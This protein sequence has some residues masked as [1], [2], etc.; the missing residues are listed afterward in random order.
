M[1]M[2][3]TNASSQGRPLE[4][5]V[6]ELCFTSNNAPSRIVFGPAPSMR[7]HCCKNSEPKS[8]KQLIP[9]RL[10]VIETPATVAFHGRFCDALTCSA[11]FLR[12]TINR[13]SSLIV[14]FKPASSVLSPPL[15]GAVTG[16]L[17]GKLSI[18]AFREYYCDTDTLEYRMQQVVE[19]G[20][21]D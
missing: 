13:D 12:R 19:K 9:T 1:P 15:L 4:I 10:F 21:Y 16:E 3:C 7:R 5:T 17:N 18:G 8:S 6:G 11:S 14:T 20:S 2:S